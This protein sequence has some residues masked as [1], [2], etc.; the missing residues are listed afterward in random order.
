MVECLALVAPKL[1]SDASAAE[2][3]LLRLVDAGDL[4]G[5]LRLL[6]RTHGT[7]IYRYCR[8]VL[9]DQALA[10]DVHQRVFIEAHRDLPK[11]ARRS[12]IPS[13]RGHVDGPSMM[14]STMK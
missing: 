5:A 9:R 1:D 7:A 6:M 2:T 3:E 12:S 14:L 10:D 11:F 8:E 4:T 13:E